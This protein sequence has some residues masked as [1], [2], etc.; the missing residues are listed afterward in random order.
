MHH[1]N[2]YVH[3][4]SQLEHGSALKHR[5]G[6]H[7]C[8]HNVPQSSPAPGLSSALRVPRSAFRA[9]PSNTEMAQATVVAMHDTVERCHRACCLCRACRRRRAAVAVAAAAAARLRH[10]FVARLHSPLSPSNLHCALV[11][12]AAAVDVSKRSV[13]ASAAA[14]SAQHASGS[15]WRRHRGLQE[16]ERRR[17]RKH[18]FARRGQPS[19][20]K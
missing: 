4:T 14:A 3:E 9:P 11:A 16:A 13:M 6:T 15:T 19:F 2:S 1:R 17:G 12:A 10:L 20:Q 18:F 8:Y 7:T 5:D